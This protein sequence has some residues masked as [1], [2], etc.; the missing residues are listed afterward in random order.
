MHCKSYSHFFSKKFQ[1][2]CVSLNLNFN[3][4]LT[5]DIVSFEQLGPDV[6]I[7]LC[8]IIYFFVYFLFCSRKTIAFRRFNSMPVPMMRLSPVEVDLEREKEVL[9]GQST[10]HT[11]I[12][13]AHDVMDISGETLEDVSSDTHSSYISSVSN[14]SEESVSP[15]K[16]TFFFDENSSQDS[17]VGFDR[18][19]RDAK[20]LVSLFFHIALDKAISVA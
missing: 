1:H 9:T 17:G 20:D 5:N 2:I 7:Y 15:R 3:E 4:S 14:H 6:F 18:D 12:Q 13:R 8:I 10:P 16:A 19:S 11:D